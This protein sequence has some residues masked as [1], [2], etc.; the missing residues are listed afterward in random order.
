M[1]HEELLSLPEGLA[2]GVALV[3]S[4]D[5]GSGDILDGCYGQSTMLQHVLSHLTVPPQQSIVQRGVPTQQ[6]EHFIRQFAYSHLLPPCRVALFS[7]LFGVLHMIRERV[8]AQQQF[9]SIQVAIVT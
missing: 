8:I 6:D 3:D 9:D 4:L 5:G 1:P 7:P 2:D